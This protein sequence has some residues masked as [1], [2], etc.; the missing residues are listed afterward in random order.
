MKFSRVV[1][2]ELVSLG[3]VWAAFSPASAETILLN[4]ESAAILETLVDGDLDMLTITNVLSRDCGLSEVELLPIIQAH[5]PRLVE[6]GFLR[7]ISGGAV[8]S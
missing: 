1:G 7:L 5:C 4:N 8:E 3:E 2:L 6:S